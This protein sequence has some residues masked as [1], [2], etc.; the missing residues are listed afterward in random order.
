MGN[1]KRMKKKAE[2]LKLV[3]GLFWTLVQRTWGGPGWGGGGGG[4]VLEPMKD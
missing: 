4:G 2:K 3:K 1:W